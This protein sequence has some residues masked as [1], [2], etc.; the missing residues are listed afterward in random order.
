MKV[1]VADDDHATLDM[2]K[3]LLQ[4]WGY[5]VISASDG[6]DAWKILQQNDAPSTSCAQ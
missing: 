4:E 2:T 5:E 1:L 6:A 3:S